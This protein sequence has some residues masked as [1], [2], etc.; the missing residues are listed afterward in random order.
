MAQY[1]HPKLYKV[2][3][4]VDPDEY[5]RGIMSVLLDIWDSSFTHSPDLPRVGDYV[6]TPEGK[7][8]RAAYIWPD[9]IQTC[10]TGSFHLGIYGASMSGGLDPG[11]KKDKFVNTGETK[12]GNFWFFHHNYPG[13][14]RSVGMSCACRV[15]KVVP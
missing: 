10:D 4:L 1:I 2:N 11:Y 7:T 6:I 9:Q 5:D 12:E 8:Q 15:F 3:H 14:D 13:A